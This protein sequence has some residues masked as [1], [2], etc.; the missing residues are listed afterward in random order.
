MK[1]LRTRLAPTPS[2]YLHVGNAWSFVLTW[3]IAKKK[4]AT[5]ELRIDDMD[6]LR[7]RREYVEDI[8][9]SLAWLGIKTE[10][11]PQSVDDFFESYS[12]VKKVK[13]YE[14]ALEQLRQS[15]SVYACICSRSEIKKWREELEKGKK[16]GKEGSCPRDCFEE[17]LKG[18]DTSYNLIFHIASSLKRNDFDWLRSQL[19]I[20]SADCISLRDFIVKKKG[21]EAAYQL[22]SVVED[23]FSGNNLIVRGRDLLGSTH[24]QGLLALQLG[25]KTYSQ[26]DFVHHGLILGK[27]DKKL[28]KSAGSHS[29][30]SLRKEIGEP[31]RLLKL[32]AQWLGQDPFKIN[33][34]EDLL[35]GFRLEQ[36]KEENISFDV[37]AFILKNSR[38]DNEREV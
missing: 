31:M 3:L 19:L 9:E 25:Y 29:L 22:I 21:G 6:S 11:G 26:A 30:H 15:G 1:L 8:F 7:M 33:T 17:G 32:F 18:E 23:E 35:F 13:Q 5:I 12:Q 27:K 24:M 2:G 16:E 38:R 34:I 28:S 36:V 10:S 37:E 4:G 20:H 14:F